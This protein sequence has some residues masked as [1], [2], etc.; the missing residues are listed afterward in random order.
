MNNTDVRDSS[1]EQKRQP[2]IARLNFSGSQ[3]GDGFQRPTHVGLVGIFCGGGDST[4][5]LPLVEKIDGLAGPPDQLMVVGSQ[6]RYPEEMPLKRAVRPCQGNPGQG[7]GHEGVGPQQALAR[8]APYQIFCVVKMRNL[9]NRRSNLELRPIALETDQT[10]DELGRRKGTQEGSRLERNGQNLISADKRELRR[11]GA[12]P[13]DEGP[14][15]AV[16]SVEHQIPMPIGADHPELRPH[17][18][19]RDRDH[20]VT[21]RLA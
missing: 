15:G 4:G 5:G 19:L 21:I 7:A 13:G 3:A 8:Q 11:F 2:E 18:P 10:V 6:A 12:L 14:Q 1:I 17:V 16:V 9:K 20:Q